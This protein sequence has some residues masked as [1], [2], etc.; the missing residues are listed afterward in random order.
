M[1]KLI[2]LTMI[3]FCAFFK[4]QNNFIVYNKIIDVT[5]GNEKI[6]EKNILVFD[7]KESVFFSYRGSLEDVNNF[8]INDEKIKSSYIVKN[9]LPSK[10]FYIK[11][12]SFT[13]D[14]LFAIDNY[15]DMN[16]KIMEQD[17]QTILGYNCYKAVGNFRGRNFIAY[18][19]T[20]LPIDLGPLKFRGLPGI[21]LKV[22]DKNN[23]FTYEA[24][25]IV[26][27]LPQKIDLNS[28]LSFSFPVEDSSY[29]SYKEYIDIENK[30]LRDFKAKIEANRPVGTVV[31]STSKERDFT[32]EKSFEWED[33]KKP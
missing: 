17:K 6:F 32:I 31:V 30:S 8:L 12:N 27:N 15:Q 16:W 3:L 1:K 25:K 9:S 21:I 5:D 11:N 23:F 29:I 2:N 28:K 4:A 10:K 14:N 22:S 13:K 26:L 19:T 7:N 24:V 33:S 18:F 20:D